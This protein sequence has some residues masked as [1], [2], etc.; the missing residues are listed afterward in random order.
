MQEKLSYETPCLQSWQGLPWPLVALQRLELIT[1][2]PAALHG[3]SFQ[4]TLVCPSKKTPPFSLMIILM[5]LDKDTLA[6]SLSICHW[7]P[8]KPSV[9]FS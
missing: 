8:L 6:Q 7:T 2:G 4:E 9:C 3:L 1:A 5:V